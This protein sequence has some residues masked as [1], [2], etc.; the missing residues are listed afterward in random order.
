MN[1]MHA[2]TAQLLDELGRRC[3][4]SV[5]VGAWAAPVIRTVC[6]EFGIPEAQIANHD[7]NPRRSRA[8]ALILSL[9]RQNHPDRTLGEIAERLKR[10]HAMVSVSERL[11]DAQIASDPWFR[12]R[13]NAVVISLIA[14]GYCRTAPRVKRPSEDECAPIATVATPHP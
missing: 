8:R 12:D 11:V 3:T 6:A 4:P 10:T 5:D 13:A 14:Q 1:L 9:L 7:R 2:T